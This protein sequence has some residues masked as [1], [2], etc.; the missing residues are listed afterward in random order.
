MNRLT[1]EILKAQAAIITTTATTITTM[2][3]TMT[4][5]HEGTEIG[6]EERVIGETVIVTV[7]IERIEVKTTL[8]SHKF[9]YTKTKDKPINSRAHRDN[10]QL[11]GR[12]DKGASNSKIGTK[13][14][15]NSNFLFCGRETR[16]DQ[17]EESKSKKRE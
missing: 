15:N 12:T 16:S 1:E 17:K 11:L 5:I 14:E 6:T 10:T 2:I 8:Y 3:D 4:A 7:V 13:T 9:S